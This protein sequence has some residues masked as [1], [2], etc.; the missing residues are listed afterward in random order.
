MI[1]TSGLMF[2]L[3]YFIFI[4]QGNASPAKIHKE[5]FQHACIHT[6][7]VHV[8]VVNLNIQTLTRGTGGALSQHV[9]CLS[10]KPLM[11]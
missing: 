6:H 9:A 4:I 2:F 11:I 8:Y 1:K 5:A 3:Y 7:N 10:F